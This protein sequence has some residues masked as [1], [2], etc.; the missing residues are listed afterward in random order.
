MLENRN[1]STISQDEGTCLRVN[2]GKSS[3]RRLLTLGVVLFLAGNTWSA[4]TSYIGGAGLNYKFDDNINLSVDNQIALAGWILDGFV[5]GSYA[6]SRFKASAD[7][8]LDFERYNHASLDSDNPLLLDPEPDDFNS[9]NQD[10]KADIAYGWE[11]NSLS[12]Y[13]R[14]WR[15]STLNT[16][17]LDTG[18]DQRQIEG[19]TRRTESTLRPAW[20]W[21][22][23]EK[24]T[25]DTS[26]QGQT[27]DYESDR[28][29]D[30]DYAT[31]NVNW[32]YILTERMRLQLQPY[33]SWFKNEADISVKSN[34]YGLQAGFLW[35]V[36]EKWQWDL[37][38]GG[39]KIY[40]EYAQ[41][42]I[43]D[44]DS[45]SYIGNT[46]L[47]FT[48]EKYGFN[49]NLSSNISPSGNGILLQ[50]NQG[51]LSFYWK[52]LERIRFDID[53]LVGRNTSTDDRI[54]DDRDYR[55]AGARLAYQFLQEW[56]ISAR[57]RYRE[58]EFDR[59]DAGAARG[60]SVFVTVS[61]R[62]P[63]EVF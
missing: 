40:S 31:A 27:V 38:A 30:Y 63:K 62:L 44:Q 1:C 24:Q 52:P 37:L 48:E 6:T 16:A 2:R 33:Y 53:G 45:S 58:Q 28:Y 23:T 25:L 15:D 57:Y 26:L 17:F 46:T 36:S 42:V 9:D 34:T 5:K 12:L 8:K 55:Q 4:E 29:V 56:W 54:D 47:S 51:R 35:A 39:S 22:I 59:A 60:N 13:G 21:Q 49:A 7:L 18:F 3:I 14:Y 43:E 19:A 61:Y 50:R 11:R 32:T 20:N 41:G 10:L